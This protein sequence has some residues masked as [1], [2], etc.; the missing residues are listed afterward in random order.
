[1]Q[2][3]NKNKQ[4]NPQK[5]IYKFKSYYVV[6]K[7]K[8]RNRSRCHVPSLNRTMQY[9]NYG[10]GCFSIHA[11]LCLNRTMQYGN[12]SM[13][14]AQKAA[15]YEFKS[16]YVVWKLPTVLKHYVARNRGLNRTMQ[17]GNLF[18]KFR[19]IYRHI[20]FKSYYVVWKQ[21]GI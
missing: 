1:M 7:R 6:W 20:R 10:D 21:E 4:Y 15:W 13:T 12:I 11:V 8:R 18:V 9:G 16:Y 5:K 3:G 14:L 2:Y 19:R 17:Y